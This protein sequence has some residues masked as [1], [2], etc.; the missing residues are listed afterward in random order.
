LPVVPSPALIAE[1]QA[2]LPEAPAAMRRRLKG[3]WGFSDE[4]FRDVVNAN[5][6]IELIDTVK[7]GAAPQQARKWWLG[8]ISRIANADEVE[9]SALVSPQ[10]VAEL[11][12]L[13]DKGELTDR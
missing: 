2:A 1:L 5:L 13:V 9:P 12:A 3:E 7:L 6:V 4:E 10:H 11:I 8:E